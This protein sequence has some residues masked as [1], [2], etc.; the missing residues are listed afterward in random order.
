MTQDEL[1]AL[2]EMGLFGQREEIR[3]GKRVRVP[4]IQGELYT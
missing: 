1:D 2:P 4:F 3:D